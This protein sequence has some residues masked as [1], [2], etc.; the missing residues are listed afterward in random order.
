MTEQQLYASLHCEP[1]EECVREER[2]SVQDGRLRWEAYDY[3]PR[4]SVQACDRGWG[5]PPPWVRERIVAREGTVHLPVGGPDGVPIALLRT[6]YG[7]TI[8]E[9]AAARATGWYATPT[10][11]RY[12]TTG[13]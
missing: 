8:A 10:E 11:A 2:Q 7:L 3:C 12:L 4:Y 9:T 1:C 13:R 6:V 5:V